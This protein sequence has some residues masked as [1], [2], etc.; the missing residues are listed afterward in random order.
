MITQD[1]I[2][3]L[4][5]FDGGG[6]R[7]LS[8]YLDLDPARQ[9]RRSYRIVFEDLVHDLRERLDE[10]ARA[11]LSREAA[12]NDAWLQSHPPR[13]KGFVLFSCAP[14]GFWQAY[15]LPVPVEDHLAFDPKPD[16]APLVDVL[17]EY[18]RYAVALVDKRKARLFTVFLGAIEE[19]EAFADF[20]P[21][22]HDQG[23]PAQARFQRHHEAHVHWHLK[24]VVSHLAEMLRRRQ[25]DRLVIAGPEEATSELRGLLPRA[26]AQ[27][28]VGVIPTETS[29]GAA[30]ILEQTLE[31]ERRV[32]REFEKRLLDDLLETAGARGRAV[33][34][35]APTLDALWKGSV[36][37]L[38]LAQGVHESG[39]EC[40]SCARLE[41]GRV[42][43]CPGCGAAMRPVHDLF[44][45]AAQHAL[46]QAG[47]VETVHGDAAAHL[48]ER[49]GGLGAFL[50]YR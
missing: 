8:T 40:P 43:N 24:R 5:N 16:V 13:G 30:E 21:G 9:V 35:V 46:L 12:E 49:C 14:R 37:T 7:V 32:E 19:S 44:H 2:D 6:A 27:R 3:Q 47:S 18:E 28:L 20:V 26:L 34:G 36:R 4:S 23:G 15:F 11:E 31:F 42:P 17:D 29:A 10:P 25:L 41:P 50:R 1:E 33:C 22:K 38:V 45:A 39:S 48:Q